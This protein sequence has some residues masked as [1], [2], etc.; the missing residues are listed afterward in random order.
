MSLLQSCG[1]RRHVAKRFIMYYSCRSF[2]LYF[3]RLVTCTRSSYF[4]FL[5][6]IGIRWQ[7]CRRGSR[8]ES[9]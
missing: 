4:Y 6:P 1:D 2:R 9:S 5:D 3:P 8:V 7:L